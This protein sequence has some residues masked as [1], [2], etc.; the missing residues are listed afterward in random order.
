[1]GSSSGKSTPLLTTGEFIVICEGGSMGMSTSSG[2]EIGSLE[3]C[4]LL[5]SMFLLVGSSYCVTGSFLS[6]SVLWR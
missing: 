2:V 3:C 4:S 6:C 1:M 5:L